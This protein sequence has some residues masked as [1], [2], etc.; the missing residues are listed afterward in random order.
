[1]TRGPRS[2]PQVASAVRPLMHARI[3]PLIP[4]RRPALTAQTIQTVQTLFAHQAWATRGSTA[5]RR[6]PRRS[7]ATRSWRPRSTATPTTRRAPRCGAPAGRARAPVPAAL[8]LIGQCE[9]WLDNAR[10]LTHGRPPRR[11]ASRLLASRAMRA[12]PGAPACFPSTPPPPACAPQE[13][14]MYRTIFESHFP[15]KAAADTVPGARPQPSVNQGPVALVALLAGG[16]VS[17]L[18]PCLLGRCLP[19]LLAACAH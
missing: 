19:T 18:P 15:Q 16:R 6:T 8:H 3:P 5:S 12:I 11:G 17:Q 7:S 9:L 1:M 10:A 13:A 2:Q 14:Y 4:F